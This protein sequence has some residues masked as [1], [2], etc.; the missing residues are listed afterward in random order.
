M[1]LLKSCL[2]LL[3]STTFIFQAAIAEDIELRYPELEVSPRASQ[4]LAIEAKK[5]KNN[6]PTF[7]RFIPALSSAA[8]TLG[9]SFYVGSKISDY[10]YDSAK[11]DEAN[12]IVTIGQLTGAAWIG[13]LS[14]LAYNHKPY[15]N[16]Y[17]EVAKLS[18]KSKSDKIARER[19]AEEKINE[20][21]DFSQKVA[22]LSTSTNLFASIALSAY[23]KDDAAIVSA[24][25]ALV[26]FA[27]YYFTNYWQNLAD[28]HEEY[29]KKI[30]GPVSMP[31][32]QLDK[33]GE[34]IS[35]VQWSFQF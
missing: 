33:G 16:G 5:E 26:A 7:K 9:A 10:N 27:P 24:L 18:S 15:Q 31:L 28:K 6:H 3:I 11:E 25:S 12:Q 14:Y 35:G 8:F 20:A 21:A 2:T 30:Y 23:A 32:I 4:R 19:F 29:K 34:L 22:F 1:K 17:R 13:I